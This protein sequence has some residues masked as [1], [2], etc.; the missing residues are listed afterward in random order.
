MQHITDDMIDAAV[1]PQDAQQV[2]L[3]AFRS[4]GHGQAAMQERIRTEAQGVKLSTLGAVIPEQKVAGAKVYTTIQ[5]QFTFV[6]VLF[7]TEDGRALA[8]FD[9]GA[10]TRLRTAACSLIAA[11]H[12]A[13]P[14]ARQMA[15]FG[16]GVQGRAHA[17]QMAQAFDLEEIRVCD[18]YALP[19]LAADLQRQCG[20]PVRLCDAAETVAG[21]DIV[22]TASRSTT[23][24][25]SGDELKPGCF[26]AAIGSSLPHTREL[27][28][29]ALERA[30][31][32]AVEWLPQTLREAG[33]LVL[34]RPGL[35]SPEKLVEL[36]ALVTGASPGRQS[37]DEITLY[38]SVGVGLEDV[39]LAGLA[40][41]R[42]QAGA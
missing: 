35:V 27:D 41:Q 29:R 23:P 17:I 14:G 6:I 40:W 5:G 10:I 19:G 31:R 26:V 3:D 2:L 7:S 11:R 1:S 8:S 15:L 39:A 38:K 37:D 36:G 28:D 30:A 21:A 9:A 34:A 32:I 18:P 13:R 25:F 22:V 20:T 4:F 16:A 12:L 33:D 24:L 42:V